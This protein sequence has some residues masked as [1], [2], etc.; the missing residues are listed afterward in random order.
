MSTNVHD[1]DESD[2]ASDNLGDTL[3]DGLARSFT[4]GTDADGYDHHYFRP[5]DAVVVYDDTGV[6]HYENLDGALILDWVSHVKDRRGWSSKG[7]HAVHGV[8]VD[9]QRKEGDR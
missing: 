2:G 7:P 8:A 9:R 1:A 3:V 4:I 5:A 6:D